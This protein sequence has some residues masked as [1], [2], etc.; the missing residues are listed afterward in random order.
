MIYR[1]YCLQ[2][3]T[4]LDAHLRSV[5]TS[6]IEELSKLNMTLRQATEN[7]VMLIQEKVETE[8]VTRKDVSLE[9]TASGLKA[10]TTEK[11]IATTVPLSDIKGT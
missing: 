6:S 11:V 8:E 7:A 4:I 9:Q 3:D 5:E 2:F 10:A 1:S